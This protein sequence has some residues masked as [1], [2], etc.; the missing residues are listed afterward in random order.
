MEAYRSDQSP[1]SGDALILKL[2]RES[3]DYWIVS[4]CFV[5]FTMLI[6]RRVAERH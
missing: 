2:L 6:A 5:C 3:E 4:R 1:E